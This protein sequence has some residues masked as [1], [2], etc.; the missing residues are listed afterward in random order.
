MCCDACVRQRPEAEDV[1]THTRTRRRIYNG[2]TYVS[3]VPYISS[4]PA[5]RRIRI[6]PG[7]YTHESVRD[8]IVYV[9]KYETNVST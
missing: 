8:G 9:C 2:G 4:T 1:R 6:I 7:A 3:H 5:T